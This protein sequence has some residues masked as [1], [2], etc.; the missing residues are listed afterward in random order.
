MQFLLTAGLQHEKS[1]RATNMIYTQ[2][3]FALAFDKIVWNTTPS[4]ISLLGS[5][6]ILG[7]AIYVAIQKQGAKTDVAPREAGIQDEEIALVE[8][9]GVESDHE[10]EH[11]YDG[12]ARGEI[13]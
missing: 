11:D 1:S 12:E 4:M 6:L 9:V 7:S 3:L 2:M 8:D 5:S 10:H 13:R